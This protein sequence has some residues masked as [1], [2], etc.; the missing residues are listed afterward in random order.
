MAR[1][2]WRVLKSGDFILA[3]AS[4]FRTFLSH[5]RWWGWRRRRK[6][7]RRRRRRRRRVCGG[8]D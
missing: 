3:L 8:G 2:H 6:R 5:E 1:V 7:R 4:F